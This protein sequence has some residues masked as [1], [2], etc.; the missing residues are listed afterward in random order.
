LF[1]GLF[2]EGIKHLQ[3]KYRSPQILHLQK[4]VSE[5]QTGFF[6]AIVKLFG[7]AVSTFGSFY[8]FIFLK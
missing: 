2:T 5:P 3:K 4:H 6:L 1:V 8:L 7:F